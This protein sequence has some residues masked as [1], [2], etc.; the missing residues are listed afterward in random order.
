MFFDQQIEI[1]F[2]IS[3]FHAMADRA[4]KPC[5]FLPP[6]RTGI[7]FPGGYSEICFSISNIQLWRGG[8][9]KLECLILNHTT[10]FLATIA[11]QL[12]RNSVGPFKS[13]RFRRSRSSAVSDVSP[14]R[15]ISR[16]AISRAADAD[17]LLRFCCG[18][19]PARACSTSRRIASGFDGRGAGCILI[20]A[21]RAFSSFGSMRTFSCFARGALLRL[22]GIAFSSS[23]SVTTPAGHGHPR[24]PRNCK[25][26]RTRTPAEA[27]V[28]DRAHHARRVS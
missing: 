22:N 4:T 10:T 3:K 14:R 16:P 15:S 17:F 19:P 11:N 21:S 6:T 9:C 26:R 25:V 5:F 13:R 23:F 18:I 24:R 2:S 8:V 28:L 27:A 20:Q 1:C 12:S 7:P